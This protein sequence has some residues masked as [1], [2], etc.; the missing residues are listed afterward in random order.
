MNIGKANLKYGLMLGPMAGFSDRAMRCVCRKFGAEYAV[1]E[2]VSAKA[3]CYGDQ[4]TCKLARI[5]PDEGPVG[6]QIF[7]SEPDIM[8]EGAARLLQNVGEGE[9]R[10]VAVDLN[11]G[12]P[13]HKIYSNGEGSALMRDPD[14]IRRIVSAVKSAIDLPVTVKM[15]AG[16]APDTV[17]AVECALAAEEGGASC[18]TVHG[19]TRVQ[20]Y[21]GKADR[22]II[23]KVKDSLHIP[24]IANGDIDS[25]EAALTMLHDTGAD[26]LMIARAAVGNPFLFREIAAALAG[27]RIPCFSPEERRETA[28]SQLRLAMEEKGERTAVSEARKQIAVYFTGIRG[29]AALRDAINRSDTYREVEDAMD[30]F[31]RRINDSSDKTEK[32]EPNE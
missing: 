29:C 25:A 4:K 16:I 30:A 12:C 5:L 8:A 19:R 2:M 21:S 7:G 23:K 27:E 24:V 10:P 6:L 3:V 28:L 13:V 15:R 18:V 31:F 17:N 20:M 26:G 1:T 32:G 14:R 9:A 22:E 11:M